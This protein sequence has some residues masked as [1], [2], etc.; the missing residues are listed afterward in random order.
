MKRTKEQIAMWVIV[1]ALVINQ[2]IVGYWL[3]RQYRHVY[4]Q[5][6]LLLEHVRAENEFLDKLIPYFD[7]NEDE[8][9]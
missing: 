1:I 8:V 9:D 2:F 6:E 5:G 4:I 3:L 7:S